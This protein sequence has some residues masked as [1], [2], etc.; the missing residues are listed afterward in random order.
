MSMVLHSNNSSIRWPIT[1]VPRARSHS[2]D[3]AAAL[4]LGLRVLGVIRGDTVLMPTMT[5]IAP[6]NA[7]RYLGAVPYFIDSEPHS[8][9]IDPII[10]ES[11]LDQLNAAHRKPAAVIAADLYGICADYDRIRE[12]CDRHDVPILE[13]TSD[14]IGATYRNAPAGSFGDLGVV[15]FNSDKILTTGG[16]AALVGPAPWVERARYLANQA[17]ED[18]L[19]N[20]H[21]ELGYEYRMSNLLAAIGNAQLGRLDHMLSRTSEIHARY[22]DAFSDI[23]GLHVLSQNG[24]GKANGARTVLILNERQHPTPHEISKALSAVHNIEASPVWKP[25]HLQRL[26]SDSEVAGGEVAERF[27]RQGLCLPSGTAMTEEQQD[28]VIDAVRVAIGANLEGPTVDLETIEIEE[29]QNR[30]N[31]TTSV[32]SADQDALS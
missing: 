11:T 17:T 16:G 22:L 28:R 18:A 4:H 14:A 8:G 1:R 21:T 5:H 19:Q 29:R 26:Y 15:S 2:S 20:E 3:P 10:L 9:N 31:S 32:Q 25:L 7:V 12:A 23:T 30:A 6:A 24:F 13:D 27:Y